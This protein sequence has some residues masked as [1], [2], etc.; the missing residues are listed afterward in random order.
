LITAKRWPQIYLQEATL[1]V[2]GNFH[3]EWG[4]VAPTR[5]FLRT[6]RIVLIATA[7]GAAVGGGV[8]VS[9]VD[10]TADATSEDSVAART[11]AR[12][13]PVVSTP[14]RVSP[15]A[16]GA[17][18]ASA[19]TASHHEELIPVSQSSTGSTPQPPAGTAA[20]A[21]VPAATAVAPAEAPDATK[22]AAAPAVTEPAPPVRKKV[23]K[24]RHTASRYAS[25]GGPVELLPGEYHNG[26]PSGYRENRWDYYS[27]RNTW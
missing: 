26:A 21:E 20:L 19:P 8:V 5:G 25:R 3:P 16:R 11:L 12:P 4:C 24:K 13:G 18:L 22:S 23:T 7:V 14:S 10:R 6:I 27:D 15:A 17:T 1:G 9:L 2:A